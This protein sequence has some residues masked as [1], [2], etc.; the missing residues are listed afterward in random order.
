[1]GNQKPTAF[2][3]RQQLI[4]GSIEVDKYPLSW[5]LLFCVQIAN[6]QS[7]LQYVQ[8]VSG[9]APSITLSSMK[10]NTAGSENDTN[11]IPAKCLP[12]RMTQWTAQTSFTGNKCIPPYQ[13][14][15]TLFPTS[16]EQ[17]RG[18]C[19]QEYGS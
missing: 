17:I 1:M 18:L 16:G 7:L 9:T 6:T 19:K 14:D 2:K 13:Y 3:V 11:T 4:N 12:F 5:L 8:P 15:D 10:H